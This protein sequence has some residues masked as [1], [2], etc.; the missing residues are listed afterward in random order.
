MLSTLED[1]ADSLRE[2]G[3]ALAEALDA[4]MRR[5]FTGPECQGNCRGRLTIQAVQSPNGRIGSDPD[6]PSANTRIMM[7]QARTAANSISEDV[8]QLM[9]TDVVAYRT[10]LLAAGYTPFGGDR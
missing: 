1:G 5:H 4:V 2:E 7:D 6:G 3:T 9:N 8:D 10:A